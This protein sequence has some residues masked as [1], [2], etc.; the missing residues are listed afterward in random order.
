M[1]IEEE[2]EAS[3]QNSLLDETIDSDFVDPVYSAWAVW[4]WYIIMKEFLFVTFMSLVFIQ[5]IHFIVW[6]EVPFVNGQKE[7]IENYGIMII[8]FIDLAIS[9]LAFPTRHLLLI[10]AI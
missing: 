3:E 1:V 8:V 2:S 4:K 5:T 10:L 9:S 7:A 6:P